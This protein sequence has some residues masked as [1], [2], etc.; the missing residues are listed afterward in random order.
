MPTSI[1]WATDVWNP[2]IGCS[3]VSP[4]CTNCYAQRMAHRLAV[5]PHTADLY[6]GLTRMT[7]GGPRWTGV[8]R[9]VPDRLAEPL[10]WKKG[11]RIFVNSMSDL[12]HEDVSN[13]FIAA[14]FGVMAACPP[15]D[16]L[17]LTKRAARMRD[18]F[19][20]LTRSA[21][22]ENGG[23]GMSEAAFC[24]A[25]AQRATEARELRTGEMIFGVTNLSWPVSNIWLGVSAEN[26]ATADE[27]IP[28][29]LETPAAVRWVS[30]EPLLGPIDLFAFLKTPLRDESL[31]NLGSPEMPG[32]DWVVQ[33][34]E[35]GPGA[36]PCACEWM[37]R[38]VDQ[39]R[40]A[41]VAVFTKQLG[42]YFTSEVRTAPA[43]MMNDPAKLKPTDF[44]P[45]GEVWAWRASLK[46][47]KG[48]DI[49]TFP[50]SLQV[51]EFPR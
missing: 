27:R 20:W 44:A 7:G 14:T 29:L 17:I 39:C 47:R 42:A 1:E 38:I 46:D 28:L 5:M 18:W 49:T 48:G 11:R 30:A 37:E 9:E 41:K 25:H 23:R 51:R 6:R 33:G 40:A 21:R 12:F 16:F 19:A 31:A 26:Q 24:L 36:R 50:G 10:R 13:E 43:D 2:V 15:H 35:S 32:L 34:G 3:L 22:G 8:V 4:G 45:S